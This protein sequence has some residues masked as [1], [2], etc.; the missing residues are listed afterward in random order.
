MTYD[1][2]LA[3]LSA[4]LSR[5][6]V[7]PADIEKLLR[8][9]RAGS[10]RPDVPSVLR[11]AGALVCFAGAA[12]LY[13]IGFGSYPVLAQEV[14]PFLFPAV[15]LGAAVLLHRAGRP[16]WEVELAGMAGYVAL[17]SASVTSAVVTGAGPGAGIV[18]SLAITA[19]VL[20]LHAAVRIVRLTGWGLSASLVAFT[21]CS[22][23]AAGI[24]NG[25]TVPWW[26]GVQG[27][28]AI[29]AGAILVRRSHPG[30]EAAW[31]SGAVLGVAAAI[32]GMAHSGFGH[33]GPWHVLLT[34]V[35]AACLIGAARFDMG[36]LMWVGALSSIVW[37][38]ALAVVV[39]QSGGWAVGVILFGLGLVG[40]ATV[41][42]RR[43]GQAA[44]RPAL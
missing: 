13:G 22:A 40:L 44:M 31:R 32:A 4:A 38:G 18:A 41:I 42:A 25:S 30:A 16:V 6:E 23:D 14:T 17:G 39:G 33:V 21:G 28:L 27:V 24:L 43:R 9:R 2:L 12:L 7:E 35:V 11:A 3:E 20:V 26:L 5:G 34:A 19:V 8:R 37:L 36:G 1:T 29:A 10:E 15:A